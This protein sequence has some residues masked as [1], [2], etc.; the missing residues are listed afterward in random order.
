MRLLITT[1]M[2]CMA[3]V[4]FGQ[5]LNGRVYKTTDSSIIFNFIENMIEKDPEMKK[6]EEQKTIQEKEKSKAAKELLYSCLDVSMTIDFKKNHLFV[7]KADFEVPKTIVFKGKQIEIP[8]TQRTFL[9][10]AYMPLFYVLNREL[11][12]HRTYNINSSILYQDE[13]FKIIMKS[14]EKVIEINIEGLVIPLSRVK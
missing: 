4:V 1:V 9:K 7:M 8:W 13:D 2:S 12:K 3:V 10:T 14:G 5:D 11:G 6:E